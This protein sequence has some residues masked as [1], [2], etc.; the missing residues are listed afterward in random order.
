[1]SAY[2]V[3]YHDLELAQ[4]LHGQA[5]ITEINHASLYFFHLLFS[6]L[7]FQNV[8]F[9]TPD[10]SAVKASFEIFLML[11]HCGNQLSKTVKIL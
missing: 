4:L 6:K 10:E 11:L 8:L 1:M 7:A 3:A 5:H 9:G 2:A